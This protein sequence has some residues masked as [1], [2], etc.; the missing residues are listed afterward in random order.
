MSCS[1]PVVMYRLPSDPDRELL[2]KVWPQECPSNMKEM[3][4]R[5]RLPSDSC[6]SFRRCLSSEGSLY[7]RMAKRGYCRYNK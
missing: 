1:K 6:C 5:F 7:L 2:D 4:I 3:E